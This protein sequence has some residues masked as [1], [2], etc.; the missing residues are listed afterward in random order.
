[1]ILKV[2]NTWKRITLMELKRIYPFQICRLLF[3][4]MLILQLF[5]T[6]HFLYLKIKNF[7]F[8]I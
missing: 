3:E 6:H 5:C 2:E 1:M 8:E 4:D 7:P